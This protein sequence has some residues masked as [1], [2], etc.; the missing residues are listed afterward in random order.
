MSS[1]VTMRRPVETGVPDPFPYMHP[2]LVKNYGKW[3]WHDRLRP[4]APSHLVVF[5][6]LRDAK[7][8]PGAGGRL[9]GPLAVIF[10]DQEADA[11]YGNGIRHPGFYGDPAASRNGAACFIDKHLPDLFVIQFR[12]DAASRAARSVEV[13]L[14][15][16]SPPGDVETRF[17]RFAF[18]IFLSASSSP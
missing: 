11:M 17:A 15:R 6:C 7:I 9:P 18:E 10:L 8:L 12:P 5:S 14:R 13:N 16:V 4:G 2:L 1:A 3:A